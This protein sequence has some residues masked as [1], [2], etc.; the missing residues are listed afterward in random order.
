MFLHQVIERQR[1]RPCLHVFCDKTAT[2]LTLY[3]ATQEK[4]VTG[5]VVLLQ[6]VTKWWKIL[7]VKQIG[8][9]SRLREPLQ[10]VISEPDDK[11]LNFLQEFGVMC[12]NMA[13]KQGQRVRQLSKDTAK[14]M[15]NTCFQRHS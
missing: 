1:V 4:Y 8:L 3:G 6:T 9:D 15:Y 11:R 14:A 2:A 7:N 13:G 5:T 12:L 10:A